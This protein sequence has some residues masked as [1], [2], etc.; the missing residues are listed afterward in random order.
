MGK[1]GD[2]G[3][4][5]GPQKEGKRRCAV[6][7]GQ[8]QEEGTHGPENQLEVVPDEC[9]QRPKL[10]SAFHQVE[11]S[12][13][14][15]DAPSEGVGPTGGGGGPA[16]FHGSKDHQEGEKEVHPGCQGEG[17]KEEKG[18][19]EAQKVCHSSPSPELNGVSLSTMGG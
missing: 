16:Q 5:Q 15:Q 6:Q 11:E 12:Q 1:G 10:H 14:G 18:W 17:K 7:Q 8:G 9:P 3:S 4:G 19:G 13:H 2:H